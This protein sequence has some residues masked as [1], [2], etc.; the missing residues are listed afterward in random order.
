M[1]Y[2]MKQAVF[3]WGNN[4]EITDATGRVVYQVVGQVFSWGDKLSFQDAE[5]RQ[6]AFI[7]QRVFSWGKTYEVHVNDALFAEI[8]KEFTFFSDK[9]T[10][11]VPGPNDY[12]VEGDFWNHEYEFLRNGSAVA[13]V[14]K[15]FF[16]WGDTYGIELTDGADPLPVLA[17]AVVIDLVNQAERRRK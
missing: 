16:T 11:D 1:K 15:A 12:V 5:G 3:A 13:R 6:L 14:S 4:F 8:T 17:T 9:Y 2:Q 10:V 7:S